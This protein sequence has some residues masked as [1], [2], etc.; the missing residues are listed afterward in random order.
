MDK[1]LICNGSREEADTDTPGSDLNDES[2]PLMFVSARELRVQSN[3]EAQGLLL[4][5]DHI[6]MHERIGWKCQ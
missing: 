1:H 4:T 6:H 3:V 5:D 2:K